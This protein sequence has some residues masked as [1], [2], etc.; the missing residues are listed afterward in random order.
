MTVEEWQAFTGTGTHGIETLS[1]ADIARSHQRPLDPAIKCPHGQ[2]S[3]LYCGL[4]SDLHHDT[5]YGVVS[6]APFERK[7][8]LCEHC[9]GQCRCKEHRR[10][11]FIGEDGWGENLEVRPNPETAPVPCQARVLAPRFIAGLWQY[12]PKDFRD[13]FEDADLYRVKAVR[14][15][16]PPEDWG[17][18]DGFV[19]NPVIPTVRT[20]A[21]TR[22]EMESR[23]CRELRQES[24]EKSEVYPVFR[25]RVRNGYRQ[26]TLFPRRGDVPYL[27]E[28]AIEAAKRRYQ[29]VL[30]LF[31]HLCMARRV[32]ECRRN[33]QEARP[34]FKA[35]KPKKLTAK[36]L[37]KL[38]GVSERT[39]RRRLREEREKPY[40][41]VY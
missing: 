14:I 4:C 20:F 7:E 27:E 13:A 36:K 1:H 34:R 5:E 28:W 40:A 26:H 33:C 3:A 16:L 17:R 41:A 9:E 37:A 18:A 19:K 25:V 31:R 39:A 30:P 22:A 23:W 2:Y 8:I 35:V 32:D 6:E 11:E 29:C 10:Y 12:E 24:G 15:P 21:I 38:L